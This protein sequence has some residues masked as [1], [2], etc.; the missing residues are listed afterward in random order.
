MITSTNVLESFKAQINKHKELRNVID[1]LVE[2][3][4]RDRL[5]VY[6]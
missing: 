4:T 6:L 3:I 2:N 1:P 5:Q